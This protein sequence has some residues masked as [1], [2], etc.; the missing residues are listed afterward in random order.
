VE[1]AGA[2]AELAHRAL[3]KDFR[4][5]DPA[6][7]RVVLIEA[8]PRILASFPEELSRKAEIALRRLRVEIQS[9]S[10]V[11]SIDEKGVWVSGELLRSKCVIWAAGVVAS[12]AGKWIG[13]PTDRAGRVLVKEDLS[14]PGDP[15]VFVI[16]DTA[17]AFNGGRLLPGV[18]PV[19]MQEGRYVASVI[20]AEVKGRPKPGP[21]VYKDKGSLATVGR[22][23]AVAQLGRLHLSGFIAWVTWLFVH[24]FYLIGFENRVLVMFQWAWAYMTFQRGARLIVSPENETAID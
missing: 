7:A 11:E 4:H 21:F 20:K 15:R 3:A 13:A 22:S 19:A 12:P 5:F 1:L 23:F 16:G 17:A 18:S 2:I 14:V 6:S 8:G 24:I 9:G 10:R